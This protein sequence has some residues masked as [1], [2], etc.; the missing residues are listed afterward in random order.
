MGSL[1]YVSL[2]RN[3]QR[4]GCGPLFGFT[5]GQ[6]CEALP[7]SNRE[8]GGYAGVSKGG[9]APPFVSSWGRDT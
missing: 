4:G 9:H 8:T 1:P 5:P 3:D 7:P 2:P 6:S